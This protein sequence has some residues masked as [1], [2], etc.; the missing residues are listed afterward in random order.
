MNN[1]TPTAVY[2]VMNVAVALALG[3]IP[4]AFR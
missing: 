2:F 3:L 1:R 4:P